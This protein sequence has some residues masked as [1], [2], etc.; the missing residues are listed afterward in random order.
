MTA[1][2][3]SV[4]FLYPMSRGFAAVLVLI[5]FFG[6][7]SNGNFCLFFYDRV[8]QLDRWY[9]SNSHFSLRSTLPK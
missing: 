8:I 5:T 4:G 3:F 6:I 7:L 1:M 2:K 9:F